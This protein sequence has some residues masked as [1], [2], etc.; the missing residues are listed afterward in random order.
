LNFIY[1]SDLFVIFAGVSLRFTTCLHRSFMLAGVS[2]RFTACLISVVPTGLSVEN[3]SFAFIVFVE[4]AV[5]I[6]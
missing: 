4:N 5:L 3:Q 1:Q 6:H 2:L